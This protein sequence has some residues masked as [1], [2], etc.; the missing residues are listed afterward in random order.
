V[1]AA[2]LQLLGDNVSPV[3]SDARIRHA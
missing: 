3:N 2:I 1:R